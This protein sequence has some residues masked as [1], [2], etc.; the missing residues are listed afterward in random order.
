MHTIDIIFAVIGLVFIIIGIKRGL[1]G[2]LIRVAA[3][4]FGFILAFLYY[5]DLTL[6]FSDLK[7]PLQ[8]KST[9]AFFLIYAITVVIILLIGW[10]IKKI[11]NLTVLGWVDRFLGAIVGL[12]KTILLTWIVC[13]SISSF[14]IKS[15]QSDLSQ[16]FIYST[17]KKLP[18][19][20]HLNSILKA[21]D[22]IRTFSPFHNTEKVDSNNKISESIKVKVDSNHHKKSHYR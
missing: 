2:E 18:N 6:Y 5:N 14:N 21:K 12:L 16:S 19:S 3:M 11:I 22:L 13:L 15:L 17:Y 20:F 4:V 7:L 1:T 8:I 9:L 10:L